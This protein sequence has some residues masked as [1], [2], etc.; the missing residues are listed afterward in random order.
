MFTLDASERDAALEQRGLRVLRPLSASVS[1][2]K[3]EVVDGDGAHK[4]VIVARDGERLGVIAS[5]FQTIHALGTQPGIPTLEPEGVFE[6]DL[7][8]EVYPCLAHSMAEG[9]PLDSWLEANGPPSMARMLSWVSQ[10]VTILGKLHEARCLHRDIKPAN[11]IVSNDNAMLTLIDYDSIQRMDAEYVAALGSGAPLL[12]EFSN[13]GTIGYMSPEQGE[14]RYFPA[15]DYFGLGR[16]L[17]HVATATRLSELPYSQESGLLW[18]TQ[19]RNLE[20]I[21]AR[22]IDRLCDPNPVQRPQTATDILD[23]LQ[24]VPRR[25]RLER[26]WRS[27][28]V[29]GIAAVAGVAIVIAVGVGGRG[30]YQEYE[31]RRLTAESRSLQLEGAFASAVE[32]L[33]RAIQVRPNDPLLYEELGLACASLQQFECAEHA[34][35]QALEL[36]PNDP[37]LLFNLANVYEAIGAYEDAAKQYITVMEASFPGSADAANNLARLRII[38][39]QTTEAIALIEAH[40]DSSGDPISQAALNKN[41]GWALFQNGDLAMALTH[42][43]ASIAGNPDRPDAYCLSAVIQKRM[44]VDYAINAVRCLETPSTLPEVVGWRDEILLEFRPNS[45]S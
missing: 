14:G 27:P 29:R 24:S 32:L 10:L 23:F 39:G 13:A 16:T 8:G 38:D 42:L 17:I 44:N 6:I 19:A 43:E 36:L 12:G 9:M 31:V 21:L 22:F 11:I 33:E 7:H 37:T 18:R 45:N 35:T 5:L 40:L 15:S 25:S 30:L 4:I 41:L 20:P 34:L 1:Q 3:L 28:V 26:L 2:Q